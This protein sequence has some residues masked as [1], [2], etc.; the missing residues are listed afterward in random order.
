MTNSIEDLEESDCILIA[1]SNTSECHPV[2][3]DRVRW[4]CRRKGASL[5]VVEPREIPLARE[6]NI[7]LQPRPGTDVA[8][9]NGMMHVIWKEGLWDK[10]F[11]QERTEQVEALFG[12]IERYSPE[13]VEGITGIPAGK[14]VQ[15]ARIYGS[16]PRA[17]FL[18]AMGLTQHISGTDNVKSVAN[19]AMLTGNIGRP[20]TGVNPLRGQNNVQG[21][22]DMGALP[23]VYCGYQRVSDINIR[24]RFEKAWG[25]P[26]PA[27]P[28]FTLTQ[29]GAEIRS[30]GVKALYIMGENPLLT[31]ADLNHV[32]KDL[33]QLA[34]VIVQD[35][36][37]TETA[38][39]ADVV[40]PAACFAEKE[41]TFT[42]TER[43]VQRVRQAV[44]PPGESLM[45]WEIIARLS[46]AFGYPMRYAS[47]E[48]IFSELV[49]LTPSYQGMSYNRLEAGGLHWPCPD[50]KHPGTPIL[51]V[52]RFAGGKGVFYAVDYRPPDEEPDPAY[53]FIL[54]TGRYYEHYHT[55]T[56]TRRA[57]G[58][59]LLCP[60]GYA[61]MNPE[62]AMEMSLEEGDRVVLT[63]RR[64]Q[65]EIDVRSNPACPRGVVFVPFH[66]QEVRINL[67]TNPACDPIAQTPE[68]K[69][70]A[71][72]VEKSAA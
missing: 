32:K 29:L 45:D 16:A 55:G 57:K 36:F 58:L 18:F 7:F 23:E 4:A 11:V 52:D 46:N 17:A 24:A 30:G 59:D 3:A 54:T 43:R 63:S 68:F 15:A 6:A 62:D 66:F 20:G 71:V 61:E 56:M 10:A 51:H 34:L 31:D 2:I 22:C 42:N 48:E 5:I 14:L 39:L 60:Q 69:V 12:V 13:R 47:A 26:L 27:K 25:R 8:W 33:A 65:V 40:F 21:A 53:P 64:G 37:L 44:S 50:D 70:C 19:L 72:K 67:L 9:L 35:I 38:Q 41:G 49:A 28:G 1:G